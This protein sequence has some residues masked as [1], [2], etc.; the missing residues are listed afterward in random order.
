MSS[1]PD[2]CPVDVPSRF[3]DLAFSYLCPVGFHTVALPN[4]EPDFGV[5]TNFFPLH[6]AMASRG[7]VLFSV[8]AR[9]AWAEGAVQDWAERVA[10]EARHHIRQVKR[11][12]IGGLPAVLLE[13]VQDMDGTEL[14]FRSAFIEDGQRL[15]N[16]SVVA[17]EALWFDL[18]PVLEWTLSSFRLAEPRG[19]RVRLMRDDARPASVK[20]TTGR[21]EGVATF[22]GAAPARAADLALADDA[23]AL[24]ADHPCNVRMGETGR[25]VPLRVLAVHATDKCATLVAAALG[26]TFDLPFGW[27]A[28]DDGRRVLVFDADGCIQISLNLRPALEGV[29]PLLQQIRTDARAGQ[30]QIESWFFDFG[31]EVSGLVLR[32]VRM[33][34]DGLVQAYL[35]KPLRDDELVPVIRVTAAEEEL[36]RALNLADVILR[37]L[38]VPV[39][40]T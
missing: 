21:P 1:S 6:L 39:A 32:H 11:G 38:H 35:V 40:R 9:P 5:T 20:Q 36:S 7:L 15:L 14:H 8:G 29:A 31:P 2:F 10:R 17:P 30:S 26:A 25:G 4:A 24:Q 13:S 27:H 33:G 28:V 3:A 18:E 22:L 23:A 19:S 37:S 34:D 16:I 12:E